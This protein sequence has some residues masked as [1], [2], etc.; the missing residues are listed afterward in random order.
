MAK[1]AKSSS[2]AAKQ[3]SKVGSSNESRFTQENF[4]KELKN[5]AAKAQEETWSKWAAEQFGSLL[6]AAALLI[7]AAVYSNVSQ[8]V[9]SPVYGS[10]PASVHHS[11]GVMASCFIGWSTNLLLKRNLPIKPA[12]LIPLIAAYIP[13]VQFFLFKVSGTFG[14]TYGPVV[15]EALTFYPLLVLSVGCTATALENVEI[16]LPWKWMSDAAPGV[17]SFAFYKTG[18]FLFRKFIQS[19]VGSSIVYTRLGLQI[20]LAGLYSVFAPSKLLLFALPALLHTALF[21]THLQLP[22]TT[23]ALNST[24]ASEGWTLLDRRES[25]TGYLSVIESPFQKFRVLRCDHSLLGGQWISP[26]VKAKVE[27]PIYAVF[28]LL[29]AVRLIEYAVM[30][31]DWEA[32][33]LVM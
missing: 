9:L 22:H 14:A 10:I 19:V 18:E 28:V 25:I 12:K 6:Q 13:F 8:L 3:N 32:S 23:S 17:G 2:N 24:L 31:P 27:E 4:E 11:K 5:L 33:A 26:P 16:R 20:L 21:N 29:E 15:I 30:V 1:Q 7:L